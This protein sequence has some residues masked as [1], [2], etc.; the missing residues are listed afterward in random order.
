MIYA[1]AGIAVCAIGLLVCVL[2]FCRAVL[3]ELWSEQDGREM[4]H[5]VSR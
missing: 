4:A 2:G 3:R 1:M 5:R